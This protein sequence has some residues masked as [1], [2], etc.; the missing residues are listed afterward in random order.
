MTMRTGIR[1]TPAHPG[2]LRGGEQFLYTFDLG[3]DWT[4]LCTVAPARI[5]T[6]WG[7]A[8][9]GGD[10]PGHTPALLGVGSDPGFGRRR[11]L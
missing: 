7:A 8:P 1:R 6:L 9:C 4:H 3:D 2:R 10:R 11:G 5:D